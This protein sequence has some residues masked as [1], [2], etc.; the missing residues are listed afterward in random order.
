MGLG[1][2]A[3]DLVLSGLTKITDWVISGLTHGIP[4]GFVSMPFLVGLP[5]LTPLALAWSEAKPIVNGLIT[6]AVT[7]ESDGR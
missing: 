2:R 4:A 3:S 1:L 5:P 7:S 6:R